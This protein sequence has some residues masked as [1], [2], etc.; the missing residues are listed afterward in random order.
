M[1]LRGFFF[2][3]FKTSRKT[4]SFSETLTKGEYGS[5]VSVMPPAMLSNCSNT[6]LH[7]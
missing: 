7:S 4:R 3:N 1:K 6:T 5:P 2:Q